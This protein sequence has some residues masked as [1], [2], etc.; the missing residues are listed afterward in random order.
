M[1]AIA[2]NLQA[3]RTRIAA[4][5]RESGRL[6]ANAASS[7]MLLAVSKTWPHAAIRE[8]H[9]AGQCEFAESY[10]QEALDK[11]SF[12]RD[13]PLA[14]HFVGPLQS[15]KTRVVAAQFD[16]VHSVEREKIAQRLSEQREAHL[17]SLQVCLQINVS[18][19]ASKS[20]VLP[21]EAHALARQRCESAPSA[22]AR[23]D[24]H[25]GSDK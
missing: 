3:V 18:G 13:I 19:E 4:A 16:W 1:T 14:W 23:T 8:A 24:V 7:V 9:A 5:E 11:Q 20:G 15:N 21:Q 6:S 10:V 2:A 17:P 12:L 22:I 25:P